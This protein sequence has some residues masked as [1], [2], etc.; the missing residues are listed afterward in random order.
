MRYLRVILMLPI[1]LPIVIFEAV[2]RFVYTQAVWR[3]WMKCPHPKWAKAERAETGHR[4][5]YICTV[6]LHGWHV[7]KGAK[8]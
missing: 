2:R 6:C 5:Y 1:V 4:I 3:G 7:E 8:C